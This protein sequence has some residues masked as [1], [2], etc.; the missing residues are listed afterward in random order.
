MA[1]V[2]EYLHLVTKALADRVA[3]EARLDQLDRNLLV[4]V[5]VVALGQIDC[6]HAAATELA[7][8]P[9]WADTRAFFGCDLVESSSRGGVR[10]ALL[11][12]VWASIDLLVQQLLDLRA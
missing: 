9:V 4:I 12:N 3:A 11:D 1:E 5:L 8:D 2:G 7:Q 10:H 6:A